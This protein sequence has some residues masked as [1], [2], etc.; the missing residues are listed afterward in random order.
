MDDCGRD[1]CGRVGDYFGSANRVDP[2][3]PI[4]LT[5]AR[6]TQPV[7]VI[8]SYFDSSIG[9]RMAILAN[10]AAYGLLGMT[11]EGIGRYRRAH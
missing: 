1:R 11:F 2:M 6:L 7:A 10:A 5:L 3:Q 8:L 4:T 9:V